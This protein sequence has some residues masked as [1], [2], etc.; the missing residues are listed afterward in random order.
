MTVTGRLT[1]ESFGQMMP[2]HAEPL[3]FSSPSFWSVDQL[4][5][6]CHTDT[7]AAAALRCRPS[8]K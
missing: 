7:D 8:W 4:A 2:V 1:R 6:T 3:T 5:F